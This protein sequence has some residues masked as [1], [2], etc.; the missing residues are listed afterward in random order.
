M[1]IETTLVNT[2]GPL[3]GWRVYP[4]IAPQ[5]ASM[6]YVTYFQVGGQT[7]DPINGD[8]P[9]LNNARVQINVW[10]Q[11]RIEANELMRDIEDILRPHPIGARPIG[12]LMARYEEETRLRGAQQDFS[13][14]WS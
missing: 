2:I 12:A 14:W 8:V 10:A 5:G 4:D 6:P 11:T 13:I 7:I 1:S 9:G 3:C